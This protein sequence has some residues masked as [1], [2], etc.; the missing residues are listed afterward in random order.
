M[1]GDGRRR[2]P[3]TRGVRL[4]VRRPGPP[5]E[6]RAAASVPRHPARLVH[7]LGA[8]GGPRHLRRG[9]G[10]AD[11]ADR[12]RTRGA[13]GGRSPADAADGPALFNASPYARD[14]IVEV[15]A[16][17]RARHRRGARARPRRGRRPAPWRTTTRRRPCA[18]TATAAPLTLDNGLLRRARRRRRAADVRPRPDRRAR[19]AGPGRARQSAP[20]APRPPQ[21][22]RRLG[23][24]PALPQPAHRSDR[25]RV[26][27]AGRR[28]ARCPPRSG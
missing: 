11:R 5:V 24:R 19:G 13:G 3:A 25:R 18:R 20:A 17:G 14:E 23:P 15:P 22:V 9:R 16:T 1:G 21:P 10:G 27:R 26:R 8:P 6:D 12:G 28:P 4:P 2:G 7:R